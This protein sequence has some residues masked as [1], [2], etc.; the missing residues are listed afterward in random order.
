M[1]TV[2][3]KLNPT[4]D[5]ELREACVQMMAHAQVERHVEACGFLVRMEG[6]DLVTAVQCRNVSRHP[7]CSFEIHPDDMLMVM[8]EAGWGVLGVYHSHPSGDP[9]PSPTDIKFW[10]ADPDLRYFIIANDNVYEWGPQ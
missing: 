6:S 7:H 9:T 10:P 2:E 8:A 1:T 3:V 4:Q 5:P